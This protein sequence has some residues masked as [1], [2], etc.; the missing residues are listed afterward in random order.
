MGLSATR[1][2]SNSTT[3]TVSKNETHKAKSTVETVVL[4]EKQ[5][6][7][8]TSSNESSVLGHLSKSS[9]AESD[10]GLDWALI[11]SNEALQADTIRT[12]TS[13]ESEANPHA[14]G[15]RLRLSQPVQVTVGD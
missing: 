4:F 9:V 2:D 6:V 3:S 5:G 8:S 7:G 1:S 15:G 11:S 12:R 10:L 14:K 13:R